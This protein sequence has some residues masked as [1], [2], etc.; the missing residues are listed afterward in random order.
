M[1]M[2]TETHGNLLKDD[3]QAL[4]NTV[5][6]VGIMGKGIALQFKRAFPEVFDAYR[7]ACAEGRVRPGRIL[8]VRLRGTDRWVLNFPTKRHWRNSSRM[9]DIRSGLDDLVRVIAELGLTSVAI[10]PLGCGNGGLPWPEVRQLI[11]AKLGDL[12]VDIRLYAPGTPRPDDMPNR[13]ER[14]EFTRDRGR[15]LA[16]LSRYIKIA[17]E[18]GVTEVPRISLV[19][20]HKVVYLLQGAGLK[21]GAHFVPHK[22]GP[23]SV[24][25]NR[26][27]AGLEGHYIRGYGDGTVGARTELFVLPEA[28]EAAEA[29]IR[30]DQEFDKAWEHVRKAIAGY[31]YPEG[32]ELLATLVYLAALHP[33][34]AADPKVLNEELLAWN[35]RKR[36]LYRFS[37]VRAALSRLDQARLLPTG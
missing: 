1:D 8:P 10:P 7:E 33:T 25:L 15:L 19:E 11:L 35:Q 27:L 21:L 36:D 20:A 29:A 12:D 2:I 3:A 18:A 30:T 37:D 5:N 13:T 6:T 9:E 24:D 23:F 17:Y 31:E 28:A 34:R 14:P 4:V 22:Y 16:A 26:E 32:L